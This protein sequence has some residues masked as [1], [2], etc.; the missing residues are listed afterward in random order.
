MGIMTKSFWPGALCILAVTVDPDCFANFIREQGVSLTT[1]LPGITITSLDTPGREAWSIGFDSSVWASADVPTALAEPGN[2]AGVVNL[3]SLSA[4]PG[5]IIWTSDAPIPAGVNVFPS[6]TTFAWTTVSGET[7]RV[8][9]QDLGDRPAGPEEPPTSPGS[10]V[11]DPD[12][13][14]AL[15]LLA[16]GGLTG[17]SS[18]RRFCTI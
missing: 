7:V 12:S 13:T 14:L 11:P 10:S 8:S 4:T 1:D 17:T 16:L 5:T 15:M 2:E 6:G 18:L 9:L 3:F